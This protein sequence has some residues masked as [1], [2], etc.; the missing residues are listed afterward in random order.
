MEAQEPKGPFCQSCGMPMQKPEDFGTEASGYRV[1]D[2]C[3]YCYVDGGFI[4]PGMS[5]QAMLNKCAS[6]MAERG[7]M[8]E[9][10]ARV[11]L[12]DILPRLK[13]WRTPVG[14]EF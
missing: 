12:A 9:F 13:R 10:H 7:I 3:H 14:A 5:M 8:P 6:A 4:D 1:N 11:M 2:Y